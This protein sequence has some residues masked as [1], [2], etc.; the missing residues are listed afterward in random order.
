MATNN[1]INNKITN[2]EFSVG[3]KNANTIGA[4]LNLLK[5]RN[6]GAVQ[7]GDVIG[8]VNFA[9]HDG[10]K[11]LM[12]CAGIISTTS[13]TIGTDRVAANLEFFT[14]ADNTDAAKQRMVISPEGKLTVNEGDDGVSIESQGINLYAGQPAFA[15]NR[16]GAGAS[17]V[18]GNGVAYH[19]AYNQTLYDVGSNYNFSNQHFVA[20]VAGKYSFSG[21]YGF[22]AAGGQTSA[23]FTLRV[24][25]KSYRIRQLN[26][27]ADGVSDGRVIN[28][29]ATQMFLDEGDTVHTEMFMDG[30]S[31]VVDL[32]GTFS[33]P[34]YNNGF[35]GFLIG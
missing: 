25:G 34:M 12:P 23:S 35:Q 22:R 10:T 18:T 32:M 14:H 6:G 28:A 7:S 29:W 27:N 9:G 3:N 26:P 16:S 20:P 1:S 8:E 21:T 33:G 24:T 5:D 30:G 17:N 4:N 31:Q 19:I 11:H 13:G 15:V 2:N